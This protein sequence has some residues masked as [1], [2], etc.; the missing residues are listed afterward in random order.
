MNSLVLLPF[1]AVACLAAPAPAGIH[2]T[3]GPHTPAA[4]VLAAAPA[5]AVVAAAPA[6]TV[7]AAAPAPA[8]TY[9]AHVQVPVTKTVHYDV[10]N[11]VTG[12]TSQ[13][14][15][16]AIAAHTVPALAV[17]AAVAVPAPAAPVVVAEQQPVVVEQPAP[18]PAPA[19]AP[20]PVAPAA[21]APAPAAVASDDTVLVE[22][23]EFRSAAYAPAA[24]APA[25]ATHTYSASAVAPAPVHTYT[26]PLAPA[27]VVVRAAAPPFEHLVTKEKVLAPVRT[28]TQ[29]TPQ[30][31]QVQPEVH[32]RKVIQ[33]VA[34]DQPVYQTPVIHETKV[35][36]AQVHHHTTYA[37]APPTVVHHHTN[38]YSAAVPA[39]HHYAAAPAPAVFNKVY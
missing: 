34:V 26:A 24:P 29:I 4:T 13:I 32:V 33:D 21:P 7:F 15:K 16:P 5:P 17:P 38:T 28:H 14:I 10:R 37:A 25:V 20:V 36:P 12:Y 6:A 9:T 35:A 30:L 2:H 8:L 11:V 22:N 39:V 18:A 1:L 19:P 27:P 3:H 23:P 31:T